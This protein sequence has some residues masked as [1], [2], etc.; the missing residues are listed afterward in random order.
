MENTII[1]T[2]ILDRKKKEYKIKK[3]T[4]FFIAQIIFSLH[5]YVPQNWNIFFYFHLLFLKTMYKGLIKFPFTLIFSAPLIKNQ[6]RL[7]LS[8]KTRLEVRER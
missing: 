1:P 5:H 6:K 8:N 3:Q 2:R 7:I 4:F